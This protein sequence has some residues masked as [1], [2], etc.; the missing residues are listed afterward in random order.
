[1]SAITG[2]VCV[3]TDKSGRADLPLRVPLD[4]PLTIET[5][6][7]IPA[8]GPGRRLRVFEPS[9][10]PARRRKVQIRWASH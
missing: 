4:R 9:G 8:L 6:D 1:M 5:P 7:L 2:T 3:R 10:I